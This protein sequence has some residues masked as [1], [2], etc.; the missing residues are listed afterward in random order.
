MRTV[1]LSGVLAAPLTFGETKITCGLVA[2]KFMEHKCWEHTYEKFQ[3]CDPWRQG[4]SAWPCWDLIDSPE[5]DPSQNK[6]DWR[7]GMS[8]WPCWDLIDSPEL[9]P[10]Q[11]KKDWWQGMSA[12]PWSTSVGKP[13]TKIPPSADPRGRASRRIQRNH[14]YQRCRRNKMHGT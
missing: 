12:W 2:T 14:D 6:K 5:L 7:Q 1:W 3:E 9:D 4:V 10:S 11:N 13:H 8:A